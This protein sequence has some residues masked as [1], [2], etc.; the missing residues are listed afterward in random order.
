MGLSGLPGNQPEVLHLVG[1]LSA[2]AEQAWGDLNS[3]ELS[4]CM[5]GLTGVQSDS[6]NVRRL[7]KALVPLFARCPI[8][9][10][11]DVRSAMFGLQGEMVMTVVNR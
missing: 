4:M 2:R 1:Q 3:Q 11:S 8:M 6:Q 10:P 7:V 9:T 5:H